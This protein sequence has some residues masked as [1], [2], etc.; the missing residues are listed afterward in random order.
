M[1]KDIETLLGDYELSC[2]RLAEA[3]L[4]KQFREKG[5]PKLTLTTIPPFGSLILSAR[6]CATERCASASTR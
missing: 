6:R 1:G 5:E 3:F 2:N 4:N